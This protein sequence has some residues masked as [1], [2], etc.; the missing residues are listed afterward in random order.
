[1]L[2][3]WPQIWNLRIRRY[4]DPSKKK[5]TASK[6]CMELWKTDEGRV[7]VELMSVSTQH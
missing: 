3:G 2:V 5:V 6:E 7:L 1:M 4:C